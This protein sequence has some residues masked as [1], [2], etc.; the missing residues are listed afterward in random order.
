ML[1]VAGIDKIAHNFAESVDSLAN[2]FETAGHIY[3]GVA[4]LI[5][6]EPVGVGT[7]PEIT[8]HFKSIAYTVRASGESARNVHKVA[9]AGGVYKSG[10]RSCE[11]KVIDVK[12]TPKG[13][14]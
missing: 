10:T 1:E 3:G 12:A 5:K 13:R 8:H 14:E 6:R 9:V 11:L 4:C 2:G 7:V